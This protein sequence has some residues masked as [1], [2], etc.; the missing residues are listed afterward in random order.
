MLFPFI[1]RLSGMR[2]GYARVSSVGQSLDV[3]TDKL[4]AYSCEKI[5]SDKLSGTTADRPQLKQ[6]IDFVREGDQLIITKLDRLARSTFHLTQ[7]A[8]MLKNKGVELIVIDQHINTS[9][10][11]GKLLFNTLAAIAEFETEIRKER[12]RDGVLKAQEKG[13]KFGPKPKLSQVEVETMKSRRNAG[14]SPTALMKE[15]KI[16]K[17][18]FY[19]LTSDHQG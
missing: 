16:T 18:T 1:H 7:I 9:T 4:K 5:F 6:C 12:Q 11:T 14:E 3:Q 8:E 19:R 15:Y 17:T 2:V 13:V 10:A